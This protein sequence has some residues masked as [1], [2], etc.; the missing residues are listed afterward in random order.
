MIYGRSRTMM[1]HYYSEKATSGHDRR[2]VE[3]MIR[4]TKLKFVTDSGVF[5][6]KGI[7]YGSRFLIEQMQ[8]KETEYLLDVGCGYGPIGLFASCFIK[9]GMVTMVD[10]NERAVSLAKENARLNNIERVN[11]MQSDLYEKLDKKD[12]ST[13]LTNPPIRAGKQV[14]HR[15]Y[16]GALDHLQK[17]GELWVVIQ[18]KQGAASTYE[19]LQH[20]F[21]NV[22]EMKKTRGYR[23][24]KAK[25]KS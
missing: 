25:K 3:I 13:I 12:F 4:D 24:L 18:K 16:E 9:N 7:D 2:F 5:S 23:I 1:D 10:I 22:E 6:K 14:V 21:G 15:I 19:K 11:I 20:L 17:G 8:L